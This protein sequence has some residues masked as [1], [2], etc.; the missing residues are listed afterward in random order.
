MSSFSKCFVSKKPDP[1]I[2]WLRFVF[3]LFFNT[4]CHSHSNLHV[5]KA[6]PL[7]TLQITLPVRVMVHLGIKT[8]IVTNAAGGLN[9]SYKVGD[10][11][12]VKDHINL[13]GLTGESPL[14]GG[15][16]DRYTYTVYM[17]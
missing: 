17:L 10:I 9:Q 1:V 3:L 12:I 8:L 6:R 14:R 4:C 15:N 7:C 2:G 16:D 13:P 5:Y 11:M